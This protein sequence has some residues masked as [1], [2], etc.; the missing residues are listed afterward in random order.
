[1][2]ARLK[3]LQDGFGD[4]HD[5]HVF[6]GELHQ[7]LDDAPIAGGGDV[8][9]A[10]QGLMATLRSRGLQAF[11]PAAREWIQPG[12]G[13]FLGQVKAVCG[14]IAELGRGEAGKVKGEK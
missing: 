2:I 1:V 8:V 14:A 3:S 11:E 7:A 4:V 10:L 13:A 5:T 9:Q 12:A 6:V